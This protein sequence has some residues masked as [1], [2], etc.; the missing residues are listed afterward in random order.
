MDE[1]NAAHLL[2]VEFVKNNPDDVARALE[3]IVGLWHE[4]NYDELKSSM[5]VVSHVFAGLALSLIDHNSSLD[6]EDKGRMFLPV[7][8]VTM[9]N[10]LEALSRVIESMRF[11]FLGLVEKYDKHPAFKIA[12]QTF[13]EY[14]AH[15]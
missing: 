4:V 14:E 15:D 9:N 7:G 10:T 6:P 1:R 8:A 12:Q 11:L 3:P 5:G 2:M 13:F